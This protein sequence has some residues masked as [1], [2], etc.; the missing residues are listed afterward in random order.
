MKF[1]FI[2]REE[3]TGFEEEMVF[4]Q[5]FLQVKV[6]PNEKQGNNSLGQENT[7]CVLAGSLE[8]KWQYEEED[9]TIVAEYIEKDRGAKAKDEA[10]RNKSGPDYDKHMTAT[11]KSLEAAKKNHWSARKT[12]WKE[13]KI[14][15]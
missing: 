10:T 2:F 9:P 11:F 12:Q 14:W 13:E 1:F 15:K 6:C 5:Y 3:R 7:Q 4:E 8:W